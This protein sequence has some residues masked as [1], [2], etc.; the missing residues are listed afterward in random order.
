LKFFNISMAAKLAAKDEKIDKLRVDIERL[1]QRDETPRCP[2]CETLRLEAGGMRAEIERL[3][4]EVVDVTR[5]LGQ[6][7]LRLVRAI[8]QIRSMPGA[9][10]ETAYEMRKIASEALGHDTLDR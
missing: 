7:R 5:S 6:T 1:R 4:A 9:D 3:R 2:Q 10:N 8:E